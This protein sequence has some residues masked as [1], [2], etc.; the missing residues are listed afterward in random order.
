MPMV[1]IFTCVP[2]TASPPLSTS[3]RKSSHSQRSSGVCSQR[4]SGSTSI[5]VHL[6]VSATALHSPPAGLQRGWTMSES[7]RL[8][9][10][11]PAD[12][13]IAG[14]WSSTSTGASCR[15]QK[16]PTQHSHAPLQQCQPGRP[17]LER[18]GMGILDPFPT[19][20]QVTTSLRVQRAYVV[21]D[22][23]AATIA[24]PFQCT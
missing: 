8:F 17:P 3:S 18:V 20:G 1:L 10:S 2:G 7:L 22:K 11:A 4:D 19:S 16:G 5:H 9:T 6:W 23:S 13:G 21:P 12:L 15:A 14:T 24:E